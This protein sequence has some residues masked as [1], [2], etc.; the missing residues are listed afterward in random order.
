MQRFIYHGLRQAYIPWSPWWTKRCI[1]VTIGSDESFVC[2]QILLSHQMPHMMQQIASHLRKVLQT[3]SRCLEEGSFK[4]FHHFEVHVG[5]LHVSPSGHHPRLN[6]VLVEAVSGST[7]GH[8]SCV[9]W[10]TRQLWDILSFQWRLGNLIRYIG[11]PIWHGKATSLRL[12][13][14]H[15]QSKRRKRWDEVNEEDGERHA[16]LS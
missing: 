2:K 3:V 9:R 1:E 8:L 16:E 6:Q 5:S 12:L 7:N 14:R 15:P 10:R 13:Q 4:G 11:N